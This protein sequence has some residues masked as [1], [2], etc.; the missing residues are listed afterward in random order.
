M[1]ESIPVTAFQKNTRTFPA[2]TDIQSSVPREALGLVLSARQIQF[3]FASSA[4]ARCELCA[5][6][7]CSFP[8]EA[9][10]RRDRGENLAFK[11]TCAP[12]ALQARGG[13]HRWRASPLCPSTPR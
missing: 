6:G 4:G 5:E 10:H 9:L 3:F 7:F 12:S 8:E 13:R 1:T 2:S 11:F